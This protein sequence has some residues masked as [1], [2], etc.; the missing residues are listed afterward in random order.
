ME[1]GMRI[2][3]ENLKNTRDLGGFPAGGGRRVRSGLLLRSGELSQASERD[4]EILAKNYRL[5]KIIDFR[6]DM[7]RKQ[8]P[9]PKIGD[10][11]YIENPILDEAAMGMTH[12]NENMEERDWV[13]TVIQ[14]VAFLK[15]IPSQYMEGIYENLIL[16]PYARTHYGRFLK[17][18]ASH[19]GTGAVLWHC[20]AGK[21]RAGTGAALLLSALGVDRSLIVDDFLRTN[22]YYREQNER[23]AEAVYQRTG[24]RTAAEGAVNLYSVKKEYIQRVFDTIELHYGRME[25]YLRDGLGMTDQELVKLGN[26]YL[27]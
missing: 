10:A 13:D 24:D 15:G 3:M 2:Q 18:L 5:K 11:E 14:V 26:L 16:S 19:D 9:D 21:D 23:L 12:E 17:L 4:K 22:E 8:K 20:T 6:T 1:Y 7:E 27:A 25:Q